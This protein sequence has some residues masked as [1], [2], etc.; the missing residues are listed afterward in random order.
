MDI[1]KITAKQSYCKRAEVGSVI[2]KDKRIIATGYNGT[3]SGFDNNC[4]KEDGLT[5]H[6]I[7]VH[8]EQNAII[9]CARNGVSTVGSTMYCTFTPCEECAKLILQ[10]GIK[11]FV[12]KIEYKNQRGLDLLKKKIKVRKLDE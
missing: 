7:V 5:D 10:S 2:V 4:E 9:Q 1:A 6:S 8:A 3:I 11:E 12:Y